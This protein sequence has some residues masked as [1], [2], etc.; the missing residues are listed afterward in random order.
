MTLK[1]IASPRGAQDLPAVASS[2]PDRRELVT[3][4]KRAISEGDILPNA[5]NPK[6]TRRRALIIAPQ[7]R[8]PGQT[9]EALPSTAA[10]VKLVYELLILSGYDRRNIRILCDVCS[11][12]GRAHPTRENILQSL[13]WLVA[14]ATEGDFRYLHF[15]G[16]GNR[17]ETDS[18]KGK[19][20]RIVKSSNWLRIPGSW[21]TELFPSAMSGER[22]TEQTLGENELV[23]YNEAL[24]TRIS[25]ESDS[26]LELEDGEELNSL[27]KVWDRLGVWKELNGY[28]S[29]LPEGSTITCVMDCCASGRILNLSRKLQGSGF[30]GKSTQ[31]ATDK[32]PL[33]LPSLPSFDTNTGTV[34]SPGLV[35]PTISSIATIATTVVNIIPHMVRY[36]RIVMQEGIPEREKSMDGIRARIFAWSACHQR[37]QSWD[38]NDFQSGLLTQTFTETCLRLG[39]AAE[40]PSRYTYN[41]LFEEVSKLVAERRATSPNPVPQFVQLW[42]SLREENRGLETSLLNSYV[43]F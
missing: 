43:E 18:S 29:R 26:E 9:F 40:S 25:E 30:R 19:E 31:A 14:D 32:P 24:I 12:N 6:P 1:V 37:Q 3:F 38:S 8:E 17:L 20:G 21:D 39:G 28:L 11:F 42:T 23:Y 27:G 2:Y 5:P 15:S 4:I 41:A 10:D 13:E 22:V 7:Y 35:S 34:T 36:A 16:H 33:F